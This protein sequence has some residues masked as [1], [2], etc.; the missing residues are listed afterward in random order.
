MNHSAKA[1]AASIFLICAMMTPALAQQPPDLVISDSLANTAMG[2]DALLHVNL[3]EIGC[4]NTASGK[5]TLF[6]DT[7]GSYN[8][9]AGFDALFSNVSGDNN[10]ATGSESLYSNLTG[11]NNDANGFQ[12]MYSNTS[13]SNNLASGYQA[14]YANTTGGYNSALG[15]QALVNSQS[16]VGNIGVGPF[17]GR[18]IVQGNFN[19]DIG[20]W[21]S[22]DESNTIRIG[23]P[24][25]HKA[26]LI[27]GIASS[28][29]TGAQVFVTASGRLGVL[30]SSE[31]YKTEI[32][33]L[34]PAS[35][36]LAQL[37]PV[38]F[39]LKT[40]PKGAIQY[41]LIAEEVDKVYPELVIRDGNGKIQ[42]IRYDELAP[43][44]LNE[45]QRQQ[46][47]MASMAVQNGSQASEI[48]ELKQQVA[49]LG[50]LARDVAEM[51]AALAALQ[52]K[53]QLVA[54]R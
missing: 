30:A 12:A 16:G 37:R 7:S 19:V 48:I 22:A 1:L 50:D 42:G 34:S 36:R 14:L 41:G 32:A 17:A 29:V 35:E 4:H 13:G 51:H 10:T 8:T 53:D 28:Q 20:S 25:Y 18:N 46:A 47:S 43:L 38:S 33:T 45:L 11:G 44:L 31:R 6:S 54:R 49:K 23:L 9:A 15:N 52:S 27:A 26:T 2:T 39:R 21:G 24:Q 5:N 3:A 40:D